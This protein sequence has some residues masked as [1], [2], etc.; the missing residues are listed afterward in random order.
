MKEFMLIILVFC[1][2]GIIDRLDK[3]QTTLST[4]APGQVHDVDVYVS[5]L[6][7]AARRI[8]EQAGVTK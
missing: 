6:R 8:L 4:M 5:P 1:S 2:F 3:L 7:V